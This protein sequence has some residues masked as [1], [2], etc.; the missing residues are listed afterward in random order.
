[1]YVFKV[2]ISIIYFKNIFFFSCYYKMSITKE[3]YVIPKVTPDA[4]TF[5]YS[6]KYSPEGS[7]CLN[8][9]QNAFDEYGRN[10]PFAS[11]PD[12]CPGSQAFYEN[13]N[14]V[15]NEARPI[16]SNRLNAMGIAGEEAVDNVYDTL[17]GNI[18]QGRQFLLGLDAAQ[19]ATYNNINQNEAVSEAVSKV[20][21]SV[22]V[23]SGISF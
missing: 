21:T 15:E 23:D 1:M 18:S 9:N 14:R 16:W 10:A 5:L 7:A 3:V 2:N 12:T 19:K 20:G 17:F 13:R 4:G 8:L 6:F 11:L 22:P